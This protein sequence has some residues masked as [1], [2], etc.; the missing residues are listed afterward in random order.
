MAERILSI[1]SLVIAFIVSIISGYLFSIKR[2]EFET[3]VW[4]VIG[5]IVITTIIAYQD[6]NNELEQQKWEVKRI[7]EKLKI[8]NRLSKIEEVLKI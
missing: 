5:A 7:D 1:S 3:L 8:Y 6:I 2:I 4:V